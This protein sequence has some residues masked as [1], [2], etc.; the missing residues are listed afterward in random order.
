MCLWESLIL[1]F[2]FIEKK[3][4]EHTLGAK[5]RVTPR[6]SF[7][8]AGEWIAR[9]MGSG[10]TTHLMLCGRGRVVHLKIKRSCLSWQYKEASCWPWGKVKVLGEDL[11]DSSTAAAW[12]SFQ[13][14]KVA[15]E[16]WKFSVLSP[17]DTELSE[18]EWARKWIP[19]Y[20]WEC[21]L[22]NPEKTQ[23]SHDLQCKPPGRVKDM[24]S[25]KQHNEWIL[26]HMH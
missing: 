26:V 21:S 13:E 25:Q 5:G 16:F 10:T 7:E 2:P 11:Q 3:V 20:S 23:V 19:N 15:P 18:P 9:S 6:Y 14:T 22:W 17:Q 8:R 24:N 1:L 12:S 4:R